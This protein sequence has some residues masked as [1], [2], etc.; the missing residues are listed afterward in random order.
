MDGVCE[1]IV[2]M[3]MLQFVMAQ[4]L[5]DMANFIDETL[6]LLHSDSSWQYAQKCKLAS[7]GDRKHIY[8]LENIKVY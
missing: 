1:N 3:Y 5:F 8:R 2:H 4:G 6:V 7:H